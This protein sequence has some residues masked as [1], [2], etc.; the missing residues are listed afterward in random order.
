MKSRLI[1]ALVAL[2]LILGIGCA[3]AIGGAGGMGGH[4]GITGGPVDI[5]TTK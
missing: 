2:T 5:G 4:G 3:H 1:A